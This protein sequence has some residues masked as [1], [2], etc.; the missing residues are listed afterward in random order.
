[1]KRLGKSG[2]RRIIAL[3]KW[4][5]LEGMDG[6]GSQKGNGEGSGGWSRGWDSVSPENPMVVDCSRGKMVP[7]SFM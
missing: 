6:G 2:G 1:V 5:A 7:N 4:E 3:M